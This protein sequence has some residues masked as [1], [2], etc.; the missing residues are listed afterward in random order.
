M[1]NLQTLCI[2]KDTSIIDS[3]KTLNETGKK[4]LLVTEN[5]KMLGVITDG[6]IRR[7]LIKN[8]D[9]K[10]NVGKVMKT[11]AK[12]IFEGYNT[13]EKAI[14]IMK[15]F[16]LEAVPVLNHNYEPIDIIFLKDTLNNDTVQYPQINVPVVIMAGGKGTR[17]YPYTKVLPKPLIPIGDMTIIERI[18]DSFKKYGCNDFFITV[19]YKKI[20]IKSYFEEVNADYNYN[21]IEEKDYFGTGGSLF[22]LKDTI[23]APFFLTNCDILLS[24]DY[25]ELFKFHIE[26]NNDIT[27]VTSLKPFQIPY[28]VI[29]VNDNNQIVSMIEKP[30]YDFQVNTGMYVLNPDV[31]EDIPKEQFF[32]ITDLL[33]EY[34]K[35]G[36]RVAAYTISA[37]QWAD[38]GEMDK[39]NEMIKR[40]E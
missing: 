27:V 6:D 33:E 34:I 4:I 38:M 7:W 19:N 22:Y 5:K 13:R 28:G 12:Y 32:N 11:S 31:L 1:K 9:L 3:L 36:K 20:L 17:L 23:D 14:Q 30:K 2:T 24:I 26:N 39:M 8:G 37:E 15:E 35:K 29:N 16:S 21:F 25:S 40:V 10:E 18:I